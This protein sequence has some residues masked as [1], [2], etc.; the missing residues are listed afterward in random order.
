MPF[1]FD[2]ENRETLLLVQLLWGLMSAFAYYWYRAGKED[3]VKIGLVLQEAD[4]LT[5]D[6]AKDEGEV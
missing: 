4:R 1:R 3:G 2:I 6:A 5:E